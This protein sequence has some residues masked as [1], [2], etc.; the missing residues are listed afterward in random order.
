MDQRSFL[1]SGLITLLAGVSASAAFAATGFIVALGREQL[2]GFHLDEWTAQTL[3]LLAGRCV[4]DSFLMLIDLIAAHPVTACS[5]LL[6]IAA[7]AIALRHLT[8]PPWVGPAAQ[9]LV[10]SIL[11]LALANVVVGFEAPTVPMRGWLLPSDNAGRTINL[12]T[13]AINCQLLAKCTSP[14]GT[15]TTRPP[16]NSPVVTHLLQRANHVDAANPA[17]LL[18]ETASPAVAAQ[19]AGQV[20]ETYN[21]SDA[22]ALLNGK[23]EL[24]LGVCFLSLLFTLLVQEHLE[25]KIWSE[26]VLAL[27]S[28]VVLFS[29][30]STVML[31][32]VYGKIVDATLF[33]VAYVSFEQPPTGD[34]VSAEIK[35]GEYPLLS[36]DDKK[37]DFLFIAQNT[38][39]TQIVEV[40]VERI[41][42]LKIVSNFDAM[43][44]IANCMAIESGN[45][46]GD[47][48]RQ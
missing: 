39:A 34:G 48:C 18:L 2:L 27:R 8:L 17:V 23:Y 43:Q 26:V 4:A 29:A 28:V 15:S 19:L 11:I 40:P 22:R 1:R 24:A 38:G 14:A 42:S 35:N 30:A 36:R 37:M 7:G 33:P 13:F 20:S 9:C 16:G 5:V 25:T 6:G 46:G 31:P 41:H 45:H 44:L 12:F 32:Y 21:P 47:Y 3:T 10:A